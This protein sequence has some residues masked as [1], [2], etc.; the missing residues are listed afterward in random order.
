[1]NW[2][3][4]A[5]RR[6]V[7]WGKIRKFAGDNGGCFSTNEGMMARMEIFKCNGFVER[8]ESRGEAE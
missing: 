5:L 3:I 6:I 2:C 1:M 8:K 4:G 7:L